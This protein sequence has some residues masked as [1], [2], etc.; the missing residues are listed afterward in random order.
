M[1]KPPLTALMAA[2]IALFGAGFMASAANAADLDYD[3]YRDGRYKDRTYIDRALDEHDRRTAKYK[4][5]TQKYKHDRYDDRDDKWR[6]KQFGDYDCLH[7]RQIRRS[8]TKR[9]W[10]DFE[11][12]RERPRRVRMKATNYNGRRFRI[13][14]DKCDAT[15]IRR[16]PIRRHWSWGR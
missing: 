4:Y 10:H 6:R 14:V 8:L 15:I 11:I 3:D 1:K 13:V 9:G 5:N 12:L 7:P 2:T 16:H